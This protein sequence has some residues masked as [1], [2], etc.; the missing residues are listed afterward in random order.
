M[1]F[2]QAKYRQ[3]VQQ[4]EIEELGKPEHPP[5]QHGRGQLFGNGRPQAQPRRVEQPARLQ[6]AQTAHQEIVGQPQPGGLQQDEHIFRVRTDWGQ[7]QQ[8]QPVRGKRPAPQSQPVV[9]RG[10]LPV[11]LTR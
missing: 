6:H 9:S 11:S 5:V 1:I 4:T 2:V 10:V 7:T 8:Q 3:T